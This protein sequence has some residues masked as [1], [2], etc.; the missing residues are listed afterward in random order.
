MIENSEIA[1][2]L[3]YLRIPAGVQIRD[4]E[5]AQLSRRRTSLCICTGSQGEP[6]AALPRIAIDD[7][8]HVKLGPDDMVVFS[9]RAIP[10][11]RE[12][13]RPGDEPH[14]PPRRRGDLRG[15]S[16]TSTFPAT[17]ARRS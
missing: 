11:Q 8:R 3:G 17:A 12:G 1:Q 4:S 5:V 14:R 2:R 15:R 10:G 7:H 6:Q 16:S 13:D 9:A